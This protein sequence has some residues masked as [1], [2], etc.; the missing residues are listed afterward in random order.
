MNK[1]TG[2]IIGVVALVILGGIVYASMDTQTASTDMKKDVQM[3][4]EMKKDAETAD[5]M[6]GDGMA[7]EGMKEDMKE[8][9]K[10]G[11]YTDYSPEKIAQAGNGDVV[12]FFHASWCP[13]C[14]ALNSSI[15]NN[16][17]AIPEGLTILKVNYDKE[18][19]LKKK[20]G[21]TSQHTLVQ[22]DAN[23]ELITKWSGGQDVAS[24]VS[25]LK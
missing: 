10:M 2:A 5:E 18:T 24:I 23:G 16:L 6:K 25:K 12:L 22:V 17:G 1:N 15:E 7:V 8:D 20:Y 11:S 21:V 9:M 19:D 4:D 14:R 3:A 13:S